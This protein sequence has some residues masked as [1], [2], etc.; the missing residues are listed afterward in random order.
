MFQR[1]SS[2]IG[3]G[4]AGLSVMPVVSGAT[5]ESSAGAVSLEEDGERDLRLLHPE[6]V[7]MQ[8]RG[9]P[10]KGNGRTRLD[11]SANAPAGPANGTE[12]SA[13]RPRSG[14]AGADPTSPHSR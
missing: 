4:P 10:P 3:T 11:S 5:G 6:V 1:G 12:L 14:P 9:L 13:L 2:S 7:P 8:A